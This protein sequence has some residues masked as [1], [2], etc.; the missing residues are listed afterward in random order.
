[1]GDRG[2]R[3]TARRSSTS[4]RASTARR[5]W[6]T[7]GCRCAPA[8]TSSSSAA[9][10]NY[11]AQ[12]DRYF[13]EYVVP[14]TNAA[15]D[16]PRRFQGHR[17]SRRPVLRLG[18]GE[19]VRPEPG[20]RGRGQDGRRITNRSAATEGTRRRSAEPER[21]RRSTLQH[22]RCVFQVL[23]RHFARYTPEMVEAGVRHAARRVPRG[24]GRLRQRLGSR[25][26]RRDLLRRRLDAAFDRRADHPDRRDPA[27]APRQHRPP[28]RRHHGAAR[29]RVDPGLDR[30]PDAVRHPARLPRRCRSST[31][32][33]AT[34][35]RVHRR[36]TSCRRAGG[37]TSTSTSSR[38]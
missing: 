15:D 30:H 17:G 2:A 11:V 31:R 19:E 32:T 9:L 5:R 22:P 36:R 35:A 25:E 14:Y 38:C 13:R 3:R 6:P 20:V 34:L 18:R 37:T 16:P 10:I 12:N 24:R 28:G 7:T 1:M 33:T 27:T 29:P 8:A 21:R 4:I 26:D 23:K